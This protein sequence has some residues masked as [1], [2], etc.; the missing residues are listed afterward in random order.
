MTKT[1]PSYEIKKGSLLQHV[2]RTCYRAQ[3]L[4]FGND[5]ANRYDDPNQHYGVLYLGLDLATA[6]MESV[7][8]KH[9]WST[10]K[11]RSLT[12]TEVERRLVRVVGVLDNLQLANLTAPN[13]MA[14]NFGL[15]LG[16]LV[17]RT[18]V[19]TKRVSA[20]VHAMQTA[21]GEPLFDGIL[22]PSRNNYP[23]TSIA[24]FNRAAAKVKVIDDLDLS[25]HREWPD[26][27]HTFDIGIMDD[28]A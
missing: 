16:Q 2:S 11:K 13:V 5:G 3:P 24:L 25:D 20:T 22:Y 19:H 6:L 12:L 7:F 1:V 9:K 27:V 18:Y 26:F 10:S 23:S 17:S 28:K 4:Y 8:H 21:T 15:N 14:A